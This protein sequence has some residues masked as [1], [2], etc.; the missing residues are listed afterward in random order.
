[1]T[2]FYTYPELTPVS[3]Q[4][5]QRDLNALPVRFPDPLIASDQRGKRNRFR[6]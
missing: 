2:T 3:L 6:S 5:A 4:L 1:M